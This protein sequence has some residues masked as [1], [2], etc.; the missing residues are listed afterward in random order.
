MD[1]EFCEHTFTLTDSSSVGL[2]QNDLFLK[3]LHF[4]L[5]PGTLPG[6]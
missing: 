2:L 1:S 3:A 6:G 4:I 5:L